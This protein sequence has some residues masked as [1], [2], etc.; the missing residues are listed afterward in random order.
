MIF[1]IF[2]L[3][4][5]IMNALNRASKNRTCICIAHR[6]STVV[7][8]DQI[9]VLDN[10]KVIESGDHHSLV[11]NPQSLYAKLWLKQHQVDRELQMAKQT[12]SN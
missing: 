3:F 10:G 7:D 6:L 8:A 11:C 12:T 4:Q 2:F 9:F 1:I 5:K